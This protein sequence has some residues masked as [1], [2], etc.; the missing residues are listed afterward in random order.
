[1]TNPIPSLF[2]QARVKVSAGQSDAGIA[3]SQRGRQPADSTGESCL[4]R[5]Y[6]HSQPNPLAISQMLSYSAGHPQRPG[7]QR[8]RQ[9]WRPRR[10]M[11]R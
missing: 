6:G 4:C 9:R 8:R 3:L 2:R 10:L 11:H 7:G 1:V 5:G